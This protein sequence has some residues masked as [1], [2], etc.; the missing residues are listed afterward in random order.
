TGQRPAPLE[1]ARI[2]GAPL[3]TA[4]PVGA[5]A[6][7]GPAPAASGSVARQQSGAFYIDR[8]L[9]SQAESEWGVPQ[10]EAGR[11]W[12]RL[13]LSFA[14]GVAL[15]ALFATAAGYLILDLRRQEA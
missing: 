12:G 1:A 11:G 14:A 13:L 3:L 10:K 4:P 9:H 6:I 7:S 2:A 5:G 15:T 8:Q